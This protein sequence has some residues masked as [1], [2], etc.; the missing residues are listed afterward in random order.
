MK[1]TILSIFTG[2]ATIA[3][4]SAAA[5]YIFHTTE[6]FP[7]HGEPFFDTALV[8]LAF[9]YRA[10]F[11]VFGAYITAELAGNKAWTATLVLGCIGAAFWL[12]GAIAN[13][14]LAP[15]WFNI[16]GVIT[17]VPL[18]LIGWKFYDMRKKSSGIMSNLH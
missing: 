13:W 8:L 7:P 2:F 10:V 3:V 9:S 6:V 1:R 5:D 16:G 11:A 14:E 12:L 17:A 15:V 18:A 4:L